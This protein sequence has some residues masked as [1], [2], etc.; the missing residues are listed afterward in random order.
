[1][2]RLN[3]YIASCG[4]CSRRKADELIQNGK[5]K[6]NEQIV[7]NLG[8]QVSET[9]VVKVEDKIISKEEKK[10]YIVLNKPKGYVTT[11]NEQFNRKSVIDLIHEDVRV[12]PV[13][14]LDMYTEGLLILTNDGEFSNKLMHPRN[15]IEKTYVVTTDTN[16]TKEQI[17][18]LKNG[19]DIG[20]Y[21]TKPA[22]VRMIGNNKVEVIISEGKNRQVRRMCESVGINLLNLRRTKVGKIDLGTLQTGKYRYLT[23][24]EK[25]MI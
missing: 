4:I 18:N 6:V 17:D 12:Y 21:F 9:D 19:V 1:M 10:V 2:E 3:K 25:N 11:N 5:V 22:K 23:E 15:K 8:M 14:R 16:V 13:G 7:K 20:D 24:E